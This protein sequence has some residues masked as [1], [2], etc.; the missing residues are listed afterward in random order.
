LNQ[1]LFKLGRKGLPVP[2]PSV[3]VLDR[4]GYELLLPVVRAG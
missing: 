4:L 3:P 2:Q 1:A